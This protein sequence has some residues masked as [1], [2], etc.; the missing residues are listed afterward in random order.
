MYST[1]VD[2]EVIDWRYKK[3][4]KGHYAFY[5]GDTL[6]G[7]VITSGRRLG[8]SVISNIRLNEIGPVGGFKNRHYATEYLLQ[9]NRYIN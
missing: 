8:W 2:G 5:L 9:F 4:Q 3:L 1:I 6:V 7:Q